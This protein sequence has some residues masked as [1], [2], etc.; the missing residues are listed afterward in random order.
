MKTKQQNRLRIDILCVRVCVCGGSE[1]MECVSCF[2]YRACRK[3]YGVYRFCLFIHL[4]PD[5]NYWR[6]REEVY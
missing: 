1:T 5:V 4:D 2:V 3:V 6:M